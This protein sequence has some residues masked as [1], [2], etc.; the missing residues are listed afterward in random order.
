[1]SE[2]AVGGSEESD[3]L[4]ESDTT[5]VAPSA[6]PWEQILLARSSQSSVSIS[7]TK[8]RDGLLSSRNAQEAVSLWHNRA[9]VATP[10][11]Q[12]R[13]MREDQAVVF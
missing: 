4:A 11:Y 12:Y 13:P 7:V 1:M 3:S 5:T 8:C 2:S 10:S 6:A 9:G